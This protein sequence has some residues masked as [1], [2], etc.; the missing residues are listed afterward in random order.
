MPKP[1]VLP[2]GQANNPCRTCKWWGRNPND[3]I[4]VGAM[5]CGFP[6]DYQKLPLWVR[7]AGGV[8]NEHYMAANETGCPVWEAETDA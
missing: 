8:M 6:V 4:I 1:N 7:Y 3:R 5:A 2:E